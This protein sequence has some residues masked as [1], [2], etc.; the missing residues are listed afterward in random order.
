MVF[1][2]LNSKRIFGVFETE[3]LVKFHLPII[4]IESFNEGMASKESV[5][6]IQELIKDK[7]EVK[8][9]F[10]KELLKSIK[11][12]V[13][14]KDLEKNGFYVLDLI[15]AHISRRFETLEQAMTL[16]D[17]VKIRIPG[18]NALENKLINYDVETSWMSL[19]I[20]NFKKIITKLKKK[21]I[22]EIQ[23]LELKFKDK[24]SFGKLDEDEA[25][26]TNILV[27]P[28]D[29]ENYDLPDGEP[30]EGKGFA[31]CFEFQK[32]GIFGIVVDP[33][34]GYKNLK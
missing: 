25:S 15:L 26:D 28:A 17:R 30:I 2:I 22:L 27:W 9:D 12:F 4:L 11:V 20:T 19:D 29:K 33:K 1:V 34:F 6:R 18:N 8:I 5:L 24:V 21:I 3:E 16:D 10:V 13:I 23:K 32:P 14:E 7:E 31:L